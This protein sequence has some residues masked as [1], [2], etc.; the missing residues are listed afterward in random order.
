MNGNRRFGCLMLLA[1]LIVCSSVSAQDKKHETRLR[2]VHG[3]VV[4]KSENPLS[5]GIVFLKNLRTKGV[6][7]HISDLDGNYRFSGLDPNTDYEIHAEKEGMTSITKTISSFD[8]RKN[9]V[10]NLKLDRKRPEK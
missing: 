8:S 9:I 2:A 5:D 4:D 1:A 10:M 6:T 7:T 3:T